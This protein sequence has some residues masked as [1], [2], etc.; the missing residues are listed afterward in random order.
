MIR[1]I[2]ITVLLFTL[3]GCDQLMDRAGIANPAKI[4]SEGRAIGSACRHAGRGLEDCYRLNPTADKPSV[5][6][7][8]KDMNE[9]MV[10]NNMQSVIPEIPAEVP[11]DP[12]T[13]PPPPK[14]KAGDKEAD[15]HDAEEVKDEK[16]KDEK[17]EHAKPEGEAKK[18]VARHDKPAAEH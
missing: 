10:K 5:F 18:P 7:G 1:A 16:P 3:A 11:V 13:A 12:L 14:K 15:Q 6:M 2:F 4:E 9:Y 17:D 8:W